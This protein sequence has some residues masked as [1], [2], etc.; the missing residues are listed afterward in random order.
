MTDKGQTLP[1]VIP[2]LVRENQFFLK[3]KVAQSDA[4]FF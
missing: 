4:K 3:R 2:R 1:I